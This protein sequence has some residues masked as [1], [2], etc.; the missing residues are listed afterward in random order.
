MR[1][2]F[3]VNPQARNGYSLKK[4]KELESELYTKLENVEIYYTK[5]QNHAKDLVK[6]MEQSFKDEQ[7]MVVAVGG[8]GTVHEIINGAILKEHLVIGCIPGG[9]GNDFMKG[10]GQGRTMKDSLSILI[11]QIKRQGGSQSFDCGAYRLG[12]YQQGF[13]VNNMGAGFD[14]QVVKRANASVVKKWLNR[15]SLGKLIYAFYL[16]KELFFFKPETLQIKVDEETYSFDDTWFVSISNQPFY[17]GGM[18]IAP[19]ANPTDG[20]LDI[21]VVHK[22]T[23]LKLLFLFMTVYTGKHLQLKEVK[24]YQGKQIVVHSESDLQVHADGEEVGRI[25]GQSNDQLSITVQEKSWKML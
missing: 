8:D 24:S 18:K 6:E 16:L 15:F 5:Y 23:R 1:T 19:Y 14:A 4:W 25:N 22:V 10:F 21:T 7:V 9:S 12:K 11:D 17:G 3:I 20:L 13:F 2:V